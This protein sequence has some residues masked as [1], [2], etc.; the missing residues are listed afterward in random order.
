MAALI[1][2]TT[3]RNALRIN[4]NNFSTKHQLRKYLWT[5]ARIQEV[6]NRHERVADAVVKTG[7]DGAFEA[8]ILP[9]IHEQTGES[10]MNSFLDIVETADKTAKNSSQYFL[11]ATLDKT[12]LEMWLLEN[13]FEEEKQAFPAYNFVQSEDDIDA[14][15]GHSRIVMRQLVR[16][17]FD[18]IDNDEDK[19]VTLV[20]LSEFLKRNNL[21]NNDYKK[22]MAAYHKTDSNQN[23]KLNYEQF[24]ALLRE[25]NLLRSYGTVEGYF[26]KFSVNQ[27]L[28]ELIANEIFTKADIDGTGS[29]SASELEVVFKAYHLG[30][31]S[32]AMKAFEHYDEDGDGRVTKEEFS[33]MLLEEGVIDVV[34]A[35]ESANESSGGGG[36]GCNIL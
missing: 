32:H 2:I 36:G 18:S 25:T 17:I 4:N 16:K 8:K 24:K 35:T 1:N 31:S 9:L 3:R 14:N 20:E 34:E 7:E 27:G 23:Y 21:D 30:D 29:I 10:D 22:V 28:S 13:G 15:A 33:N 11:R 5:A 12:D 26:G 6:L 19:H